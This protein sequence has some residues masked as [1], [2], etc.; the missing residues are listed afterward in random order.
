[1]VRD[2][3]ALIQ[4]LLSDEWWQDVTVPMLERMRRRLRGLVQFIEKRQRRPV[5]TDFE[6]QLGEEKEVAI[7]GFGVG[8]DGAKFRAKAQAFLRRHL[9]HV[10]IAKLHRNKPLTAQDLAELER[11]LAESGI[12]EADEIRQAADEGRGLGL[13]VRSLIGLDREAAK[14]ALAGFIAGRTL[15]ANQLEFINKIVDHLTAHGAVP[16]ERLYES[17]FTDLSPQGPEALFSSQDLDQL[18]LTLT[19][20]EDRARVA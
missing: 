3:M 10:A 15:S 1:M 12:A 5:Y 6:D 11:M 13:F 2:E 14:E 18:I 16:A 8:T 7:P 20:V 19:S 4:D 9:D 17:P